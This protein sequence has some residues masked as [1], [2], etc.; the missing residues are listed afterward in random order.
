M[1][2]IQII[3]FIDIKDHYR[4]ENQMMSKFTKVLIEA[5]EKLAKCS[6]LLF[7]FLNLVEIFSF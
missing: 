3:N 6:I 7:N 5:I 2:L 4:T 1:H